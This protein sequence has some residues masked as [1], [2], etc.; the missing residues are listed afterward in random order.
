MA[1]PARCAELMNVSPARALRCSAMTRIALRVAPPLPPP[2]TVAS[3]T[4]MRWVCAEMMPRC[5]RRASSETYASA[6]VGAGD[7]GG[8]RGRDAG[9]GER[10]VEGDHSG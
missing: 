6:C 5:C 1:C 2:A 3:G 7:A 8:T 4:E 9:G 10:R